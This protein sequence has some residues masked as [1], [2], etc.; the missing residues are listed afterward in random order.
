MKEFKI[1][2]LNVRGLC[3][4]VKRR[5]LF[6]WLKE[7][8]YDVVFLQ[9]TY[10]RQSFT[11]CFNN[12][13]N[14]EIIHAVTDSAHSRGVCMLIKAKS[15]IEVIDSYPSSD[16]RSLICNIKIKGIILTLVNI[17]APNSECERKSFF[18][19]IE[20]LID[21]HALNKNNLILSGDFNCCLRDI[22]RNPPTH[23]MDGSRCILKNLLL[24][25]N[26]IDLWHTTKTTKLVLHI[27]INLEKQRVGWI[28]FLSPNLFLQTVIVI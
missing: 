3:N 18:T 24:K 15:N 16:G 11:S 21:T 12:S 28:I 27:L 14:G 1:A 7:L 8:N 22:D 19:K 25:N 23:L 20:S 26:L 13:W 6:Y 5:K 17:Y 4:H 2:T 9:E 10:C